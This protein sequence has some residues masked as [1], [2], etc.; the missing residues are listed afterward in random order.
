MRVLGDARIEKLLCEV[1]TEGGQGRWKANVD[2]S[3]GGAHL[4][5]ARRHARNGVPRPDQRLAL[6]GCLGGE[7][8]CR[9][10]NPP[11]PQV[12]RGWQA[13]DPLA[14]ATGRLRRSSTSR[15]LR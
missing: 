12:G 9:V 14:G 3:G 10:Q 7:S 13:A 5:C 1:W 4:T 6:A 2:S 8:V 11:Q 15:C